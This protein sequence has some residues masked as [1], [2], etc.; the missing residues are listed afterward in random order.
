MGGSKDVCRE[1]LRKSV[2]FQMLQ[3]WDSSHLTFSTYT[4]DV[5]LVISVSFIV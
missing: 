4:A 1:G 3:E 2:L 5:P